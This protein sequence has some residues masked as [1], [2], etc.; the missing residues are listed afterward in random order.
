MIRFLEEMKS[1]HWVGILKAIDEQLSNPVTVE[2][3]RRA[4][5]SCFG[6]MGSLNDLVFSEG[7]GNLPAGYTAEQANAEFYRLMDVLFRE[8]RL[9]SKGISDRLLW[10]Y[11]EFKHRGELPPRIKKAFGRK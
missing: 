2:L 1:E 5:E 4:L 8:N 11:L 3:G 9:A 6:G 10:R 7:N